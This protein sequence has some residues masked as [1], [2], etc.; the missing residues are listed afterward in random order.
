MKKVSAKKSPSKTSKK[1]VVY[2]ANY[3][4]GK[5]WKTEVVQHLEDPSIKKSITKGVDLYY[6][7]RL[8]PIKKKYDPSKPCPASYCT[9]DAYVTLTDRIRDNIIKILGEKNLLPQE[10]I[11]ARS[12]PEDLSES[13]D[14]FCRL[15]EEITQPYL[16]WEEIK[17]NLESYV[18][19][20][21]CWA[22]APT[23]ELTLARLV[24]PE[25]E[26]RVREG[27]KHATVINK[28]NTKVFDLLYWAID[29]RLE[30]YMFGDTIPFSQ[31][32]PT[33]G[34]KMAYID[35]SK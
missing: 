24:E 13:E 16:D 19:Y 32:D 15:Y 8:I 22:W 7:D 20:H 30:N 2:P 1:P 18:L 4:F 11:D 26:W 3:D 6:K 25:E 28:T 9:S 33:R 29:G 14:D 5:Y 31:R 12:A 21:S 17:Y 23:F 27:A 34:G 35:S 10:F